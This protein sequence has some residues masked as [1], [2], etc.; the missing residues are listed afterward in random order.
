MRHPVS[1]SRFSSGCGGSGERSFKEGA[2]PSVQSGIV[3]G[4]VLPPDTEVVYD[5]VNV[6]RSARKVDQ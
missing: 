5:A 4:A 3:G 6:P 1:T 2:S